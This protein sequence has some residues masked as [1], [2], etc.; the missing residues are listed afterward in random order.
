MPDTPGVPDISGV[1]G[2]LYVPGRST[3]TGYTPVFF[4]GVHWHL[5]QDFFCVHLM[6]ISGDFEITPNTPGKPNILGYSGSGVPDRYSEGAYP[7][8]P[9][10]RRTYPAHPD[11]TRPGCRLC[12]GTCPDDLPLHIRGNLLTNRSWEHTWWPI[13]ATT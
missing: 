10:S 6:G 12:Q 8:N 4:S 3:N 13:S 11:G 2:T 7:T 9:V 1:A 5:L